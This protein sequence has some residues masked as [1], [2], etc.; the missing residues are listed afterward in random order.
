MASRRSQTILSG[1]MFDGSKFRPTGVKKNRAGRAAAYINHEE[2]RNVK[3][4]SPPLRMPFST[5]VQKF[6]DG[7]PKASVV[8]AFD[9][10]DPSK[11]G[12]DEEVAHF[13][14]QNVLVDDAIL[15]HAANRDSTNFVGRD[16]SGLEPEARLAKARGQQNRGIK[17]GKINPRTNEPY[18]PTMKLKLYLNSNGEPD[19]RAFVKCAGKPRRALQPD[20][21]MPLL[22]A[23][24][25]VRVI[26][27]FGSI[28]F[29]RAGRL[30]QFGLPR[31][32][33]AI[34]IFPYERTIVAAADFDA[35]Q[36]VYP[37]DGTN[38]YGSPTVRVGYGPRKERVVMWTA[39]G[40]VMGNRDEDGIE[41]YPDTQGKDYMRI[42]FSQF[43]KEGSDDAAFVG[44]LQELERSLKA[45]A[46]KRSEAWFGQVKT[47]DDIDDYWTPIARRIGDTKGEDDK[48]Q[49][50]HLKVKLQQYRRDD[51]DSGEEAPYRAKFR[52]RDGVL[53]EGVENIREIVRRG[54]RARALVQA[55]PVYI[56]NGGQFGMPFEALEVEVDTTL[57]ELE[58]G[59][60]LG[61]G[62]GGDADDYFGPDPDAPVAAVASDDE[63]AAAAAVAASG[64]ETSE[65]VYVDDDDADVHPAPAH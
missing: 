44:A 65:A 4:Q 34:E 26:Y 53:I 33:E 27:R 11:E 5:T 40:P 61:G 13:Y 56:M 54:V 19:V 55:C 35:E 57:A 20:E 58:A 6:K 28:W 2:L 49:P 7:V 14:Q 29:K 60:G 64:A 42:S 43:A 62:G 50:P 15:N 48:S 31:I 17:E 10:M 24:N 37:P 51:D 46:V 52:D 23:G 36:L 38:S 41:A 59:Q 39:W 30:N 12:Y 16:L 63:G 1:K 32:L 18:S 21:V 9:N 45:L 47:A 25:R 8:I 22:A 3:I